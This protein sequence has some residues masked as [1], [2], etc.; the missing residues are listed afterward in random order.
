MTPGGTAAAP[1]DILFTGG[2]GVISAAVAE[3]AVAPGHGP[4]R[5]V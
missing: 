4:K 1:S 2:T 3:H 5:T